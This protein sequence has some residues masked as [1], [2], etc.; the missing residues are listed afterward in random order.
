[1]QFTSRDREDRLGGW[2]AG[3]DEGDVAPG[4]QD[5]LAKEKRV[6]ARK[7]A[8]CREFPNEANCTLTLAGEESEVLKAAVEH[9]VS[10]HGHRASEQLRE[11]IR[12]TMKDEPGAL[13][14]VCKNFDRPD[15]DRRFREHG[16]L[17][18][19]NFGE[20][21]TIGKGIFEPG[22]SW[23]ADVK[24]IAG[25]E[26][27]LAGHTG[28]CIQGKM[29][30]RMDD[31][32]TFTIRAGDAFEIA[33]GHDARVIGDERCVLVDFGGFSEYAKG[34]GKSTRAA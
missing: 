14:S 13:A 21:R 19:L 30:I 10:V 25:T 6:M 11:E 9:A 7:I 32:R 20:G 17:E 31:G 8:D 2:T 4:M 23:S 22:W 29:E 16:H 24:P 3:K 18:V 34:S 27:C 26:S 12:K 1:V 28:Y 15:E 33:P 5:W